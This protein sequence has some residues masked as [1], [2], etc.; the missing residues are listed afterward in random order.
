MMMKLVEM[1]NDV[2]WL[3]TSRRVSES[4]VNTWEDPTVEE[5]ASDWEASHLEPPK[6]SLNPNSNG[7]QSGN[8]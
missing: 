8:A 3:E 1:E 6:P 7:H 2:C 4:M 5:V